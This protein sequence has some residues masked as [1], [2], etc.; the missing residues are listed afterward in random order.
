MN[1]RFRCLSVCFV[2]VACTHGFAD[3][4]NSSVPSWESFFEY[5]SSSGTFGT[6][7]T[8]GV[9]QGMWEGI[10]AGQEY[11]A[12]YTL[13]PAEDG[14]SIRASHRMETASGQVISIGVGLQYWDQ[15]TNS[16][17]SS[18]SGFDQGS[19][20]SGVS[21]VRSFQPSEKKL[22]WEYTET[23]HGKTTKYLQTIQQTGANEKLQVARKADGGA[24][25]TEKLT[26]VEVRQTGSERRPVLQRLRRRVTRD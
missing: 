5:H 8:K 9:T 4:G 17:L 11:T 14:K 3:E 18:Y 7:E 22:E 16:V 20:F 21:K 23:S 25:W 2:F 26:R 24:E 12:T 6:F 10:E 1:A 15:R 13:E 19:V